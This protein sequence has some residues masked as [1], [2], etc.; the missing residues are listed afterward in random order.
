MFWIQKWNPAFRPLPVSTV[1]EMCIARA[2][3]DALG[4]RPLEDEN[5]GD[6]ST[7][8]WLSLENMVRGAS[9]EEDWSMVTFALNIGLILCEFGIGTEYEQHFI[10]ALDGAFRCKLRA[11]RTAAWRFDGE[12]LGLIRLALEVHDEQIK[13]ATKDELRTALLEVRRR[14]E[15]GNV[16]HAAA[17]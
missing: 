2:A 12:A 8:Y 10:T 15:E 6:L 9:T 17:A 3:F 13:L 4:S 5:A 1:F 14:V 11:D 16:Y 7:A